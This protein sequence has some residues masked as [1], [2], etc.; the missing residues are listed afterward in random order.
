M[1]GEFH[2]LRVIE[3]R[4][5]TEHATSILFEVPPELS[6][7]FRWK[8][9]Q[10]IT[11]RFCLGGQEVR[12]PYSISDAPEAGTPLRI[13]VKRHKG[14]LVSNHVNQEVA[15][16]DIIDVMPPFGGFYL[17]PD[18]R[19]RR[20]YYFFGAGSGITPLFAMIRSALTAEPYSAVRL[21]YGNVN[22]DSA[23]FREELA[24]MEERFGERMAVHHV[25]SSP[26]WLSSFHY[27]KR[28]RIDAK[29]VADFIE[30]HPPYAQDTRYYVCGPAGMNAAVRRTLIGMDVPN[31]RIHM[32]NYGAVTPP[33][34]SVAGIAAEATVRLRGTTSSVLVSAGQTVLNAVRAANE[35]PPYSCE[36][37]VCGAC[38][39]R[40]RHGQVHLRARMALTDAEISKGAILTCQA[41]PITPQLTVEYD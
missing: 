8:P 26:S 29:R 7:T 15:V 11:L 35:T 30:E 10:H 2:R 22:A 38:R 40:L 9:G 23:I 13:T 34:D 31:A 3:T 5:E 14:G 20:T 39:A 33:D 12:R 27:W 36:S 19:A 6:E 16:G 17:E 24:R 1:S 28:G 18:P 41:L 21:A 25:L 32:E 4:A 37:G